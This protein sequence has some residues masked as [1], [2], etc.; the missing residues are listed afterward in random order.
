MIQKCYVESDLLKLATMIGMGRVMQRTPHMAH[1][2]A[3]NFPAE[4]FGEISPYPKSK[5]NRCRNVEALKLSF[6]PVLVIV[7]IAQYNVC[8]RV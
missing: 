3:T 4:V 6:V 5:V 8:G 1:I 2:E 7:M